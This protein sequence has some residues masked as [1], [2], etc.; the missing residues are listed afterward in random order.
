MKKEDQ[1]RIEAQVE[2]RIKK[3]LEGTINPDMFGYINIFEKRKQEI[4]KKEYGIEIKTTQEK[5]S[6]IYID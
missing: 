2:E 1:E 4:L 5:N 6:G 3:E